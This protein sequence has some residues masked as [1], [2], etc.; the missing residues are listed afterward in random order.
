M[1][2][3]KQTRVTADAL[4]KSLQNLPQVNLDKLQIQIQLDF[5]P[6]NAIQELKTVFDAYK[7]SQIDSDYLSVMEHL[8]LVPGTLDVQ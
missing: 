3:E 7:L 2:E 6:E 5:K 8:L 4:L 1:M